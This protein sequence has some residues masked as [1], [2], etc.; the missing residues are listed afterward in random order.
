MRHLHD[1]RGRRAR[2]AAFARER[3]LH[4]VDRAHQRPLRRR[5][6]QL[7]C[8]CRTAAS[9][10]A[11]VQCH[12]RVVA[13]QLFMCGADP[14]PL[15][16][17]QILSLS[18]SKRPPHAPQMQQTRATHAGQQGRLRGG[19][20]YAKEHQL[21]SRVAGSGSSAPAGSPATAERPP[22]HAPA[23]ARRAAGAHAAPACTQERPASEARAG[24]AC[25]STPAPPTLSRQAAAPWHPR[26]AASM[27]SC[28][29]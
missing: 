10:C 22:H 14:A 6:H 13:A 24:L 21:L 16:R 7:Q 25:T 12:Q 4:L 18:H 15:H 23:A 11:E 27:G 5:D 1:N 3:L 17:W 19:S 26:T 9:A 29:Q 20:A 2:Q 28:L 8:L